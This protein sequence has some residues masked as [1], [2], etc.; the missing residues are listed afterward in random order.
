MVYLAELLV[1]MFDQLKIAR[2]HAR[3]VPHVHEHKRWD[4][5][6]SLAYFTPEKRRCRMFDA[7]GRRSVETQTKSSPDNLPMSDS[8]L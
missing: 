3:N 4:D 7:L 2:I 1:V 6:A 5:D 8:G